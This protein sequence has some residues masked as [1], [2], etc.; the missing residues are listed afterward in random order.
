MSKK[1]T[2]VLLMLP[3]FVLG[4]LSL[5]AQQHKSLKLVGGT[6]HA[7]TAPTTPQLIPV[8]DY[9]ATIEFWIYVP[10]PA[11]GRHE[12]ISE[13]GDGSP[14][15]EFY[16]GYDHDS[17]DAI[18]IGT[19]WASGDGITSSNSLNK[20]NVIFPFG[21]WNHIALTQEAGTFSGRL[22]LN[23]VP[24]DSAINGFVGHSANSVGHLQLG[25]DP[26]DT[27]TLKG[28][29]DGVRIWNVLRTPAQIKAGMYGTVSASDPNLLAWYQMDEG[30][31]TI[32]A[33]NA[34]GVS[35]STGTDLTLIDSAGWASGPA[36]SNAN[37]LTFDNTLGTEITI[38]TKPEYESTSGTIEFDVKPGDLQGLRTI[39]GNNDGSASRWTVLMNNATGDNRIVFGNLDYTYTPGFTINNWYHISLVTA[40]AGIGDTTALFVNGIYITQHP[41]GY[42]TGVTGKPLIIGANPADATQNWLGGIDE[43]RLWNT[44]LTQT[45]IQNNMGRTLQGTESGLVGNWSFNQ[46][47]PSGDNTGLKV[48][49]DNA[50][51]TNNGLLNNNFALSGASSNFIANIPISLPVTFGKFTATRIG[52]SAQ[53]KWQTYFESNTKDFIILRS[54]NGV[55]FTDIG[56]TAASGNS[57]TLKTYF[58]IDDTPLEGINYYRIQE[59]DLD[60]KSTYS[61][62]RALNFT[63]SGDLIWY[64]TGARSVEIRLQK[65]STEQYSISDA[66]GHTIRNGR[67]TDGV[68]SLSGVPGGIYLVTVFN[69]IGDKQTTKVIIP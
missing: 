1:F 53:L 22:Y 39:I 58:F 14:G 34:T 19:Y 26:A 11:P 47:I 36:I 38:P 60:L 21:Q 52:T 15:S 18:M 16:I 12:F 50:S 51:L 64:T 4:F 55:N 68:T 45:D 27:M 25:T 3:L 28:S 24:V 31:G 61:D 29:I 32:A 10:A 6:S 66:T 69:G 54:G 13:V 8:S 23:G 49:V 9:E 33:N 2:L 59:R 57:S 63:R 30:S 35:A 37:A 41:V 65:G 56:S 43:V 42:S 40:P 7:E 44:A 20:T 67:L 17:A 5:S 62:V 46:G 48:A